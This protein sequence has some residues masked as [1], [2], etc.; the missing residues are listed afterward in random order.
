MNVNF[1]L[2]LFKGVLWILLVFV[3]FGELNLIVVLIL[4][5]VGFFWDLVV[6]IVLLIFF[7]LLLFLI[8]K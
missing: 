4:I 5:I 7:K 2:I 6:V 8:S 1:F 3:L